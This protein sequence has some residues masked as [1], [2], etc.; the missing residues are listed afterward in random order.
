MYPKLE[1]VGCLDAFGLVVRPNLLNSVPLPW[2]EYLLA[3]TK[4]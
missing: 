3:F 4:L 2:A 1:A